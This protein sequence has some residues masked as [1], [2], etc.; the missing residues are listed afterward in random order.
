[1]ASRLA[2]VTILLVELSA[3]PGLV[4]AVEWC[5]ATLGHSRF[6][7]PFRRR[8]SRIT[9]GPFQ[10]RGGAWSR[11]LAVS[12]ARE[13]LARS[14]PSGR[15]AEVLAQVWNGPRW[16]EMGGPLTYAEALRVARP[17][18]LRLLSPAPF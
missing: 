10:I 11:E 4:R 3:R 9:V 18:A 12:Q 7:G 13:R 1:M 17:Y 8:A 16:A 2:L 14:G 6:A 5:A 15:S